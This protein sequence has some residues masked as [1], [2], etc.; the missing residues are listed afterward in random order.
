M[1]YRPPPARPRLS[2]SSP[3]S[4]RAVKSPVVPS[5]DVELTPPPPQSEPEVLSSPVRKAKFT[6]HLDE[7]I[8]EVKME[9]GKRKGGA[10]KRKTV[11]MPKRKKTVAKKGAQVVHEPEEL[12][13]QTAAGRKRTTEKVQEGSSKKAKVNGTR[14]NGAEEQTT[15]DGGQVHG[16]TGSLLSK[17]RS[18]SKVNLRS[19][20]GHQA[21]TTSKTAKEKEKD[22]EPDEI[23]VADKSPVKK[24]GKTRRIFKAND[25][26]SGDESWFRRSK[27]KAR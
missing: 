24:V 12:K 27:R 16:K 3:S 11:T 10:K 17:L 19:T 7:E 2:G 25:G 6:E 5:G 15:R 20:V 8:E 14:T 4:L 26:D 1:I 18:P 22:E 21:Q 23:I 9:K 13:V